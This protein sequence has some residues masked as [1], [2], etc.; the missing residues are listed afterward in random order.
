MHSIQA[1]QNAQTLAVFE[2]GMPHWCSFQSLVYE[3]ECSKVLGNTVFIQKSSLRPV[4]SNLEE[5][6]DDFL[7][8]IC[9]LHTRAMSEEEVEFAVL[10]TH[11]GISRTL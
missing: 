6:Q 1:S 11:P 10:K 2:R 3:D 5:T 7:T 9:S 4:D 8:G